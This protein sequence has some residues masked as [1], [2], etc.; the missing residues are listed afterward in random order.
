[1]Y[2]FFL[3]QQKVEIVKPAEAPFP[4]P[5]DEGI[6]YEMYERFLAPPVPKEDIDTVEVC[7]IYLACQPSVS[8]I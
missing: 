8:N 2:F 1:M 6:P 4:V 5:L 7:F 3:L